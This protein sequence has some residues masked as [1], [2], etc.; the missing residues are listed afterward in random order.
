MQ[1]LVNRII[2]YCVNEQLVHAEDIP[3]FRY[4]LEKRIATIVVGIPF[5]IISFFVAPP[6]RAISFFA[7]YFFVRRYIGGYHAKTVQGCI[8]FSLLI[9]LVF[10]GGLPYLLNARGYLVILIISLAAVLALAPHNH[11]NMHFS[12]DEID[13]CRKKGHQR[14]CL[15]SLV[16]AIAYW[17][18]KKEIAN[19]C[20]IGITMAATLLC[21]GYIQNWRNVPYEK[22]HN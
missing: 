13:L 5:L 22:Q 10:L 16:A 14:V 17:A 11:P 7:T 15:A 6:T 19:G 8:V 9:E 21:L 20:T 2:Q 18:G 12:S 1:K 3:W 4:G